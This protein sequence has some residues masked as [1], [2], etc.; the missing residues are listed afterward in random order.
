MRKFIIILI[1]LTI[2]LSGCNSYYKGVTPILIDTGKETTEGKV[3]Y[4][5]FYIKN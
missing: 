2:F 5:M 4:E 1:L 3:I